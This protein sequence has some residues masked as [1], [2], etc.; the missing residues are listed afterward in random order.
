MGVI[1]CVDVSHFGSHE[2]LEQVGRAQLKDCSL[3]GI[4]V[5]PACP[6]MQHFA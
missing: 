3:F 4:K 5:P 6:I 2:E 1:K